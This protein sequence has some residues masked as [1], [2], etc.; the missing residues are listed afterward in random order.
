MD[1]V[2]HLPITKKGHDAILTVV[3]RMSKMVHL[4]PT[5]T[6]V[7]AVQTAQLFY[8]H[9][10]KLHGVPK[11]IVSDRDSRFTGHFWTELLRLIGTKQ[12]MSTSFH[13]QTDG[14]TERMIRIM[15][16]M[17]RHYLCRCRA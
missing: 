17:L 10:W 4:I 3:D 13:P 1:F 7:T 5:K 2:I 9:V 12:N 15:E 8:D 11:D 14:Q 6:T 16:D